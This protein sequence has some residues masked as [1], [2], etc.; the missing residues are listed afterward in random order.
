MD[1]ITVVWGLDTLCHLPDGEGEKACR[2]AGE[3]GHSCHRSAN[4]GVL[5]VNSPFSGRQVAVI[6]ESE[7][8]GAAP[9]LGGALQELL[10]ASLARV[11]LVR[12]VGH[13]AALPLGGHLLLWLADAARETP[14]VIIPGKYPGSTR[15]AS[16]L[17]EEL[18]SAAR[19]TPGTE[20]LF[21]E[22]SRRP[23]PATLP[24]VLI[25]CPPAEDPA[26]GHWASGLKQ[27]LARHF[28]GEGTS[29]SS[30]GLA[31]T[32]NGPGRAV[33][34]FW[35]KLREAV[36]QARL[37][38]AGRAVFNL[39]DDRPQPP[40]SPAFQ[41]APVTT[42]GDSQP[43]AIIRPSRIGMGQLLGRPGGMLP[44]SMTP[45]LRHPALPGLAGVQPPRPPLVPPAY[46][47]PSSPYPVTY[48]PFQRPFGGLPQ[49]ESVPF[50][51]H[52]TTVTQDQNRRSGEEPPCDSPLR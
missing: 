21:I 3:L 5:Q 25:E 52:Q 45:G 40:P 11:N 48:A 16:L 2:V 1:E 7:G 15:L 43:T 18:S 28:S 29:L 20:I 4:E 17:N 26:I 34:V 10:S 36:P 22:G 32:Q 38:P 37:N 35:E 23:L 51:R 41:A 39:T 42:A 9:V 8:S 44:P 13:P 46:A 31:G 47:Y 6:V 49:Q 24:A 30:C 19:L 12:T 33:Q 14:L 27:G 50:T